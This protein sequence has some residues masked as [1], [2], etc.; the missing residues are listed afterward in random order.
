MK[1][2]SFLAAVMASVA[3]AIP[4]TLWYLV[5]VKKLAEPK[6]GTAQHQERNERDA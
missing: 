2:A 3:A 1:P 6:G 5:K 4:A